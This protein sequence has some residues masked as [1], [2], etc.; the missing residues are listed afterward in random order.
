M[1]LDCGANVMAVDVTGNT[2]LHYAAA[3]G[4]LLAIRH[5]VE[6][7][8]FCRLNC[9]NTHSFFCNVRFGADIA[10]CNAAG[11]SP[12]HK[13]AQTAS[14]LVRFP[15]HSLKFNPVTLSFLCSPGC[16]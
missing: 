11:F 15:R 13:A 8:F 12:L 2:A 9:A 6:L 3:A 4:S 10:C 16:G 1:L 5:L 14:P 7:V